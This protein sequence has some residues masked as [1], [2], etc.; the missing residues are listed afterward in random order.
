MTNLIHELYIYFIQTMRAQDTLMRYESFLDWNV[1]VF[2]ALLALFGFVLYRV[3]FA[4]ISFFSVG[5]AWV[6]LFQSFASWGQTIAMFC[7]I[8]IVTTAIA[9]NLR[10]AGAVVMSVLC[11]WLIAGSFT[12]TTWILILTVVAAVIVSLFHTKYVLIVLTSFYGIYSLLFEMDKLGYLE[13][14]WLIVVALVAVCLVVQFLL[15]KEKQDVQVIKIKR[16][17]RPVHA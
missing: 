16:P 8:C 9:Y 1:I 5:I 4:I 17:A 2:S 11:A 12:Q 13:F 14:N 6:F 15:S 3:F 7:V 10:K